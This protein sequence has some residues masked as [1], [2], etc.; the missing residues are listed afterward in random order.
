MLAYNSRELSFKFSHSFLSYVA[1]QY[2]SWLGF[3]VCL[4]KIG[5]LITK[6]YKYL[7]ARVIQK[8]KIK[9]ILQIFLKCSVTTYIFFSYKYGFDFKVLIRTENVFEIHIIISEI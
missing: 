6:L 3:I 2:N 9:N 4:I 7:S 5:S 1:M 8:L